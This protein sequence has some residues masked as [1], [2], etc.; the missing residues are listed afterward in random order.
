MPTLT[1][2]PPRPYVQFVE[3]DSGKLT[4]QGYDFL[5]GLYRRVGGSLSDLNAATLLDKTWAEPDPIGSVT[6]STG[7]FTTLSALSTNTQSF[8]A[9]GITNFGLNL[10][11]DLPGSMNQVVIGDSGP[12]RA[13]FTE[14]NVTPSTGLQVR[15]EPSGVVLIKGGAG[16]STMD[17]VSI[18]SLVAAPGKFT[19]LQAVNQ[20]GCNG[21]SIQSS[22]AVGATLGAYAAGANGL[23]TGAAMQALVDKVIAMETA[24]KANGIL[25]V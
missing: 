5:Y 7:N 9:T 12:A 19:T 6:P 1:I 24:L 23:S 2:S 16:T 3:T 18:G 15:L 14:L 8:T 13:T 21:A 17:N 4:G 22:Y 11:I 25:K 20:F 10:V